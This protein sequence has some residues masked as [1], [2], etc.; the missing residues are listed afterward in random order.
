MLIDAIIDLD[1]K[2]TINLS[3]RALKKILPF[4]ESGLRYDEACE[5]A[6][7]PYESGERTKLLPPDDFDEITNPVVKR[8][9]HQTRKE[10]L[11]T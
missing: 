8:S 3:F 7:Y 6:G 10:S 5:K 1:F 9:L 4:M 11:C 2:S